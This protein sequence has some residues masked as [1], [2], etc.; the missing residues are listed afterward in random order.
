M[1]SIGFI[2]YDMLENHYFN[3]FCIQVDMIFIN[4]THPF[5]EL[6]NKSLL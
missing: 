4:K 5:N 1:D 2:P 6:V 3:N